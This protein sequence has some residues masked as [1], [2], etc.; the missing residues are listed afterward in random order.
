MTYTKEHT[1]LHKFITSIRK[2]FVVLSACFFV[3]GLPAEAKKDKT[4]KKKTTIV[5]FDVEPDPVSRRAKPDS[6]PRSHEA[7]NILFFGN[8]SRNFPGIDI[9]HYQGNIDWD[10]LSNDPHAGFVYI[11]ATEGVDLV[12]NTYQKNVNEAKRHG[13]KVGSYHF[14]R[15]NTSAREQF[16]NF[17]RNFDP[18]KQ[19]LLPVV[20]VEVMPGGMSKSKFDSCLQELLNLMEKEYGKKPMIYTGKNFYN[21][22]FHGTSFASNYKF[23]IATYADEQPVLNSND[24]YLIWQY[25][26]KGRVKGIKGHV[27]MNKFV[28]RHVI[29]EIRF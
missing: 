8:G 2:C 10:A 28:G 5:D 15:A 27:D 29:N 18:Q 25:S 1:F 3:Y 9:S 17:K 21:K 26:A 7:P 12:D 4:S 16:N 24:D 22:H 13:M 6:H 14:F 11:K 20:D 19:D 23:W